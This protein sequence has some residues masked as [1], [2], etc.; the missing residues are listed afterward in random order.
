MVKLLKRQKGSKRSLVKNSIFLLMCLLLVAT[1]AAQA[2]ETAAIEA[3]TKKYVAANS[4]MT[5]V[6]VIVERIEGNFARAKI[7]P[8]GGATDPAWVFL[9]NSH[10]KWTGLALG[11]AFNPEDYE[12]L[13][14][15]RSLRVE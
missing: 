13:G 15:P 12:R 9:K 11:T 5:Q 10:G 6:T 3:A 7:T 4:G 1:H 14:I 2:S 8:E